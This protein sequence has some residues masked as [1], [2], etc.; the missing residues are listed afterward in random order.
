MCHEVTVT[1]IVLWYHVRTVSRVYTSRHYKRRLMVIDYE[2]LILSSG[3]LTHPLTPPLPLISST[4]RYE[5]V[6]LPKGKNGLI[7]S[8]ELNEARRPHTCSRQCAFEKKKKRKNPPHPKHT[9]QFTT[10]RRPRPIRDGLR[11]NTSHA[12]ARTR[13]IP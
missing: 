10:A 5:E 11:S 1:D 4:P 7:T 6:F 12:F 8:R 9:M 3:A 13:P 2:Q